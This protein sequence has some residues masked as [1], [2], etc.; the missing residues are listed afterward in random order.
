MRQL[1]VTLMVTMALFVGCGADSSDR[2]PRPKSKETI[3]VDVCK[4]DPQNADTWRQ[5]GVNLFT[6]P[7]L[8]SKRK[9]GKIPAC[10]SITVEVLDK[11]NVDGIE[12][13]KIKYGDQVG[14]QTK[15]LLT[16]AGNS[17]NY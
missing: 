4:E 11:K 14:W 5:T 7:S 15:R 8:S 17:G 16:D 13:Y 3:V 9:V 2:Q 6:D 10:E 12:F 1:F